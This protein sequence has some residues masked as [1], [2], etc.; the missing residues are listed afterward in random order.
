[1]EIRDVPMTAML[2]NTG[3]V[4][5]HEI[6][7]RL[8]HFMYIFLGVPAKNLYRILKMTKPTTCERTPEA[9]VKP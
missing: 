5:P 3:R 1:V 7:L 2:V 9:M 6:A 8:A 4:L